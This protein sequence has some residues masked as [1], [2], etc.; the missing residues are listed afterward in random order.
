[1]PVKRPDSDFYHYKLLQVES[2]CDRP[3]YAEHS[4]ETFVAMLDMA[5]RVCVKSPPDSQISRPLEISL[6]K[7]RSNDVGAS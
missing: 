6:V 7:L 1:M 3:L 5:E 2:L 4:R